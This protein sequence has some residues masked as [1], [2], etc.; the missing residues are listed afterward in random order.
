M[1]LAAASG[2]DLP[3]FVILTGALGSGKTTLLKTFLE[4]PE[5]RETGIIVNDAG[6]INIDGAILESASGRQVTR[7]ASGC[8]CC[9]VGDDLQE[10]VDDLLA[11]HELAETLVRRIILETS[12]LAD[13]GPVV[14]AIRGLRQ[15]RFK[16]RIIATVDASRGKW[17]DDFLPHE[18]AQLAA[19]QSIIVTKI[20][21]CRG[22]ALAEARE[23]ARSI[24]P[25]A[26]QVVA[27]DPVERARAAFSNDSV[28]KTQPISRFHATQTAAHP[29]ISILL[30]RWCATP[31]WPDIEEWLENIVGFCGNRLLRVKGVLAPE[32]MEHRLLIN[33]VGRTLARPQPLPGGGFEEGLVLILRDVNTDEL[34]RFSNSFCSYPPALTVR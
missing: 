26:L 16:L 9:S 21:V 23:S 17:N 18:P 3:E 14:R 22:L 12:G 25:L 7:A 8:I 20:D 15:E 30:A 4:L 19:A 28:G 24:N 31:Q 32:G 13:P 34:A 2:S 33:A 1:S 5:S 6:E 27:T 11:A 29:R 10:A